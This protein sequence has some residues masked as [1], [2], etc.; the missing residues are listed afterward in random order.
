VDVPS[1]LSA[2][3]RV[4]STGNARK[5]DELDAIATALWPPGATSGCIRSIPRPAQRFCA[6]F[7]RGAKTWWPSVPGRCQPPPRAPTGSSSRRG[8]PGTLSTHRAVRIVRSIRPQGAS[9]CVRRRLASEILRDVRAL[10][11]KIANLNERIEAEIEASGTTLTEI[12]GMGPILLAAKIMG[13][14]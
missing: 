11:R 6:S 4:L 9:A 3:V 1:K 13:T 14:G 2:R 10:E 12:F 8:T 5:N 7:R